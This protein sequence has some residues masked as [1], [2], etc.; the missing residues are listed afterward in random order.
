MK[1]AIVH[2][3]LVGMRGGEK[4]L[5][6]LLDVFPEADVYSHVIDENAVSE[7]VRRR[8]RGSSFINRLPFAKRL[9]QIYL[10][11]MPLALEQLDLRG[12]DLVISSES[13]P[14][15]GVIVDPEAL[16][17]CYCH[18]PMRYVW[19]MYHDYRERSG[20]LKKLFM[21][22]LLHYL[23]MWDVSTA[24]RVTYF[25]ANSGYVASRIRQYYHRHSEVIFPPVAVDEFDVVGRKQGYY[26][27]VGELV[28]YKRADLAVS[29]FAE[30][31]K[32]LKVVGGGE[33]F[34]ELAAHATPN[35]EFLGKVEFEKLKHLYADA[36]A[37]I[38]PGVEDFG[39]VPVEAMASGT[40]VIA[41]AK[42]GAL[43][44][45]KEGVSGLFFTEQSV[46]SLNEAV[47]RFETGAVD[48]E[49]EKLREYARQFD[50]S[51]FRSKITNFINEKM[52]K[53]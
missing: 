44:T 14:A 46:E 29:A 47:E 35:I 1:V 50:K 39:M 37:L 11:F 2:Y 17:V 42:G 24:Q 8:Y 53:K 45:V 21:P 3:W 51:H 6:A 34:K 9:Y 30:N 22:F 33:Q 4:V 36:E 28:S 20:W 27:L 10:P 19:D 32:S 13:G 48:F 25:V 38:F 41:Y 26:L 18:S 49:P 40:P 31:G 23:R 15:K 7:A 52:V 16:H 5:E 43:E 12:Y